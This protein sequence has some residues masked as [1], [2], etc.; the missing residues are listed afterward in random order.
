MAEKPGLYRKQIYL[1]REMN[2]RLR[3]SAARAGETDSAIVREALEQYLAQ[4]E[5]RNTPKE[6]NPVLQM[7]GMFEGTPECK[8]VSAKVDEHLAGCVGKDR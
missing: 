8:E 5:R 1:T 2:Q 3:R 7:T 6:K 4:E